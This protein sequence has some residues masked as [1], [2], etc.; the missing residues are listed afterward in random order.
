MIRRSWNPRPWGL[1]SSDA[2]SWY[3]R[4]W[5]P[6][7]SDPR[8][9]DPR[10]RDLEILRSVIFVFDGKC[11]TQFIETMSLLANTR[12]I[13]SRRGQRLLWVAAWRRL[14]RGALLPLL[15]APLVQRVFG[16]AVDHGAL[17]W[18]N[19][20]TKESSS[21][22]LTGRLCCLQC[23]WCREH[24]FMP[25]TPAWVCENC[26]CNAG[27]LFLWREQSW[28]PLFGMTTKRVPVHLPSMLL[29]YV[30]HVIQL[31]K[32]AR[33]LNDIGNVIKLRWACCCITLAMSFNWTGHVV[34]LH[35]PCRWLAMPLNYASHVVELH[36]PCCWVTPAI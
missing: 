13:W 25:V 29:N 12:T 36:R 7:S 28:F 2:T 9:W 27:A 32:L 34:E 33:S 18:R 10:S 24:R 20:G 30:G 11:I 14:H 21:A 31:I 4:S 3:P 23:S 1:R 5:D 8:S 35:W 15:G 22:R 16:D 26:S 17:Q 19:P 6:R